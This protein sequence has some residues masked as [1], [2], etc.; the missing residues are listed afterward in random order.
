[1]MPKL[2]FPAEPEAAWATLKEQAMDLEALHE[3]KKKMPALLSLM[4]MP[5]KAKWCI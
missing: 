1:M 5:I 4:K 2:K 3:K